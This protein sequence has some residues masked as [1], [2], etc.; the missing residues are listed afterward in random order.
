VINGTLEMDA[1]DDGAIDRILVTT[2]CVS[3]N[4]DVIVDELETTESTE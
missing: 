1:V 2:G 3:L 4:L